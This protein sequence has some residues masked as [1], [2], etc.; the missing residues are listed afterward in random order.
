M[1]GTFDPAT[2]PASA[3]ADAVFETLPGGSSILTASKEE[4]VSAA[5]ELRQTAEQYRAMARAVE[6]LA[7]MQHLG[8]TS[9]LTNNLTEE[10]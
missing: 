2:W 8:A 7:L 9:V 6:R 10:E 5:A 4:L 1:H 3:Q